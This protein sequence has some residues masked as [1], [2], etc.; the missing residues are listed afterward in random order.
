FE[1]LSGFVQ[2]VEVREH[3]PTPERELGVVRH[4]RLR[5][6]VLGHRG[7][8]IAFREVRIADIH[9]FVGTIDGYQTAQLLEWYGVVLHTQLAYAAGDGMRRTFA[10]HNEQRRRL[11]PADVAAVR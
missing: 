7:V 2:L 4:R 10:A 11:P 9:A 8:Q 6:F 5:R 3:H 1:K